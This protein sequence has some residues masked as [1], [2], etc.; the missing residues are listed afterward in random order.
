[1]RHGVIDSC[2]LCFKSH[3]QIPTHGLRQA[4]EPN[5]V[6]AIQNLSNSGD[7]VLLSLV[8]FAWLTVTPS[9]L[10]VPVELMYRNMG[11]FLSLY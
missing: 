2:A 1:M 5:E 7:A 9:A 4:P 11:L 3:L 10:V 8:M 6:S